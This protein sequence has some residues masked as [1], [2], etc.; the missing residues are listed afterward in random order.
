MTHPFLFNEK[1]FNR[2]FPFYILINR[3]LKVIAMGK[4]MS[5]LLE[6]ENVLQFNRFFS[7]SNPL[8]AIDEFD[9]LIV[10]ESQ[11][12]IL[13][14]AT[15]QKLLF[16]GQFEYLGETDSMLFVGSPLLSSMKE[17]RENRLV[18]DDFARHDPLIDLLHEMKSQEITNE[19]L[20]QLLLTINKQKNDLKKANKEV[21][22]IALFPT[23]SPDPIIRIN[24]NG[25]ILQNNP[26]AALLDFFE[27]ENTCYRNDDFFKLVSNK[28]DKT[29][30]RWIIEAHSENRDYSFVCVSMPEEG[31]INIYG[32]D[33]TQQKKDEQNLE[34]LSLVARANDN[35]V[36]FTTPDGYITWANEGFCKLIGYSQEEVIGKSPIDLCKGPLTDE[37]TL[38]NLMGSFFKGEG[39]STEIIYYRKDKTWFWGRSVSQPIKNEKGIVTEFFGIIED[40]TE[41]KASQEKL[42]VLSLIAE[43]N[44]NAVVIADKEG[45][46]SWVNKSFNEITGY[47]LEEAIGQKPGHLLQG[48]ETDKNT[49]EYLRKQV[50]SGEPFNAEIINYSK[51]G[52]KYW[53]R[54]QGQP[55]KNEKGEVT[56]FFALEEDITKEKESEHRF[57]QALENIGDNVWEHDFKT[58]KTYFSKSENEFLGYKTDE[59]TNNKDLWW[60]SVHEV[61]KNLLIE[62]DRKYRTG[63]IDSHSLE[64]RI[65]HNNGSTKW[66]LDRGVVIAKDRNGKPLRITGTHT[67]I[68]E[69]KNTETQLEKQRKF[70]EDILNN[71]PTDIAVF[72]SNH[73]YL[74]VNPTGI[75]NKE[76]RK[77]IIGKRDEDYCNYRNKP[78]SIA[79]A[80]RKTFNTVVASKTPSE[81]EE[82]HITPSGN[83]QHVLRRWFPVLNDENNVTLVIGYGIDITERKKF[84][85]ALKLNEEKYRGIIANMNLGLM[86]MND[87]GKITF[88]NQTLLNMTEISEEESIGFDSSLFLASESLTEVKERMKNRT[89]GISEAYEVQ[90]N[91]N[92]KQGW[93]FISSAP[94]LSATGEHIGSIKICLDITNQKKLEKELIKSREQAEQLT[95]AKETFLAN[96]SHEIRTPMNA[97]M[98]MGNQLA[99]TNLSEQQNF[100]LNTINIAAENLL[101][102]INDILDLSKIEAG[103]LSIEQIGFEPKKVVFNA[104]QVLMLKAEEKGIK[105]TN[106]Y[107]DSRLSSI[108]I[109]DPYRLNQVLLNLI[110]NAVKF[111]EKGSVDVTCEVINITA[112]TQTIQAKVIDTGIGM[113]KEFAEKLFDKFSQ[114]YESV[115][116]KYG[117]TG[118][119]MSI[120]KELIELMGGAIEV[121]ST[122][123]KGT[124]VLFSIELKIGTAVD[125]ADDITESITADFLNGKTI[126]VTDDNEM[127]RLVASTILENYGATIIEAANGEEAL[128]A[129][130]KNKT[131]LVLMD[132]QMPVLNGF[133][134]A[135]IIRQRGNKV[136]VIALTANAIKG[137]NEKCFEV[138][139][140]D[141]ITKPFKEEEFLK[142]IAHWLNAEIT[143]NENLKIKEVPKGEPLYD[144]SALQEISRGNDAFIEKMVNLF[145][146]QS[147]VMVEQIKIAYAADKLEVMGAVAHK[148][149]PSIDNLKINSLKQVIRKIEDAGKAQSKTHELAGLIQ[150][151]ED[152]ICKTVTE[153][154]QEF[155]E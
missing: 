137:E 26:A 100:Y 102:I 18:I 115:S 28:I 62:N 122:K 143:Y 97:I 25:E 49:V 128:S 111:T 32:R 79:E 112:T 4:S 10:L 29:N 139:M 123:G 67:D 9:D 124:T 86:E 7:I 47:S 90:T 119:G 2:L 114:E 78:L 40:V 71:M 64:Y 43:D 23:Q 154:K 125:I 54:V 20:K 126:L 60:N 92:N 30:P 132:I 66:V 152:I 116:R 39:F 16:R 46:I 52:N 149:K 121:S 105:L 150:L 110:S 101:V 58:G 118:L 6:K 19:D 142:K 147:Q 44:I 42:K 146:Q 109:G 76:L 24:F 103:K 104:L 85:E 108:L 131:D 151:T 68:T 3:D 80:R 93:W 50:D 133:D 34:R 33:I 59:L 57:R 127:N 83:E 15:A 117:G 8:T 82:K 14:S 65:T 155:P 38:Y 140:N 136:P 41:E 77:W 129:L 21:H 148:L 56:G 107:C 17:V 130:D 96:M 84:E 75:K 73:E 145:C 141:Y 81:W 74:F 37:L 27:I 51:S 89:K 63:E 55:I 53:L 70:Y 95:K 69:R 48:P 106:S 113:D 98:G 11:L 94:K 138:G 36:L 31:Y 72:N 99:K 134:T 87:D 144:L 135:R 61:D 153:L 13:E 35:G 45:R 12:V 1:Q 91:I 22:D 5:K 120:C 88:A